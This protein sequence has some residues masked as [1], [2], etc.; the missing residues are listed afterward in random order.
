MKTRLFK[1]LNFC[2]LNILFFALYIN[3]IHKG[4]NV[5][6]DIQYKQTNT[7]FKATAVIKQPKPYSQKAVLKHELPK[8]LSVENNMTD[9]LKLYFN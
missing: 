6:P 1:V 4:S 2:A 5:I 9:V 8:Q 7:N 3:F